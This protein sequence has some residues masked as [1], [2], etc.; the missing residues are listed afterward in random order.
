MTEKTCGAPCSE[1]VMKG[2]ARMQNADPCVVPLYC[3]LEPGHSNDHHSLYDDGRKLVKVFW[4]PAWARGD[5]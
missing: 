2:A 5:S 3:V 4:A 1:T